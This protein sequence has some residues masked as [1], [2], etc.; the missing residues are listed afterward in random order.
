MTHH[1]NK[2][3]LLLILSTILL[4]PLAQ[5]EEGVTIQEE[6]AGAVKIE[7]IETADRFGTIEERRVQA[8]YTEIHFRPSSGS[9]GYSLIGSN[10]SEQTRNAHTNSDELLIPSWKVFNW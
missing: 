2:I 10:Q 3:S 8:M 9:E 7:T 1:Y 5:A 4:A 6:M